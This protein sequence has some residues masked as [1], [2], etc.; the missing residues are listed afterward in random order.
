MIVR[1]SASISAWTA[2]SIFS[3]TNIR[4]RS[5]AAS[6]LSMTIMFS[7]SEMDGGSARSIGRLDRIAR[8]CVAARGRRG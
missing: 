2:S 8:N 7:F 4:P 6:R 1:S 3:T 5:G